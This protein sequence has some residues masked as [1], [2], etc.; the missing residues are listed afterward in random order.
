MLNN[1]I[2][3]NGISGFHTSASAATPITFTA[4]QNNIIASN[5]S[6][7][8]SISTGT[9]FTSLDYNCYYGASPLFRYQDADKS[10]SD[11]RAFGF[12]VHGLNTNPLLSASYVPVVGS[13]VIDAGIVES[14][15]TTDK[16]GASRVAPWDI[17]AFEY[18]AVPPQLSAPKNLLIIP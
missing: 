14:D 13:P 3:S 16:N 15:F 6:Y 8:M 17:G 1:T 7:A 11:W 5:A 2:V 4:F 18:G 10:W 9:S 12:D